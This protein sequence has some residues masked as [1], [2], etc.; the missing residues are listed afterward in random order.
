M[1]KNMSKVTAILSI[2]FGG[3]EIFGGIMMIIMGGVMYRRHRFNNMTLDWANNPEH[4][5]AVFAVFLVMGVI[6]IGFAI[7]QIVCGTKLLKRIKNQGNQMG[8]LIAILVL[9]LIGGSLITAIFAIIALCLPKDAGEFEAKVKRL[10][11]YREDGI[12]TEAQYKD[13]VNELMKKHVEDI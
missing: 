11:Q 6:L 10:K 3:F 13:K 9:S 5:K 4:Y 2:V 1:K 8:Y 7:A 12:I